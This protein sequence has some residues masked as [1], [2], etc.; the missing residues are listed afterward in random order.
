MA[1]VSGRNANTALLLLLFAPVRP[2]LARVCNFKRVYPTT[3]YFEHPM[4]HDLRISAMV[5]DHT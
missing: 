5:N 1:L 3:L 2:T 4:T